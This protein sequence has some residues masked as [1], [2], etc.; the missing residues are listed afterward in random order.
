MNGKTMKMIDRIRTLCDE[1]DTLPTIDTMMVILGADRSSVTGRI[2]DLRAEGYAIHLGD[3]GRYVVKARPPKME[4]HSM[5]SD[6]DALKY[7]QAENAVLRDNLQR[8]I[9]AIGELHLMAQK[10]ASS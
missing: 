5:I 3:N 9:S 4:Q 10:N 7:A 2:S 6:S 1:Q 8:I